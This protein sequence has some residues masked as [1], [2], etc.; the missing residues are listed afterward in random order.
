MKYNIYFVLIFYLFISQTLNFFNFFVCE[1]Y[2]LSRYCAWILW[3]LLNLTLPTSHKNCTAFSDFLYLTFTL[4]FLSGSLLSN[5]WLQLFIL[6][7][8]YS[9]SGPW[10]FITYPLHLVDSSLQNLTFI[11]HFI[12]HH[13]PSTLHHMTLTEFYIGEILFFII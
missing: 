2:S 6:I 4:L 7:R 12:N 1:L 13:V 9:S 3:P 11:F 5:L 8:L 10:L